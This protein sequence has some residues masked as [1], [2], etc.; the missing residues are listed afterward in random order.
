M[1]LKQISS[2]RAHKYAHTQFSLQ[3]AGQV[4]TLPGLSDHNLTNAL[5]PEQTMD[6]VSVAIW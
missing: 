6:L 1:L 5:L 3:N 2:A 4:V